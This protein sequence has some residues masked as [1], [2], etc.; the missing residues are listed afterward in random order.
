M[1]DRSGFSHGPDGKPVVNTKP[2][3]DSSRTNPRPEERTMPPSDMKAS[4]MV[5]PVNPNSVTL[6]KTNSLNK[7][8]GGPDDELAMSMDQADWNL[9]QSNMSM[10]SKQMDSFVS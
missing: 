9:S 3:T 4:S 5:A 6:T 8:N 7:S 2:T 1:L 10:I